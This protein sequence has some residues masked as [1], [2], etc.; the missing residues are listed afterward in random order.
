VQII[1]EFSLNEIDIW[2]QLSRRLANVCDLPFH[3]YQ[4]AECGDTLE[5]GPEMYTMDTARV[6]DLPF[7]IISV[8]RF[9][10]SDYIID[11]RYPEDSP[12]RGGGGVCLLFSLF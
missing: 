12:P 1:F 11:H 8:P 3:M 9:T 10:Q 6:L 5:Q 2:M 4:L 7:I